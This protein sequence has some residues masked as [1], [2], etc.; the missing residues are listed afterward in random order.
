MVKNP[1]I[2]FKS[3]PSQGS[4]ANYNFTN[5]GGYIFDPGVAFGIFDDASGF[6]T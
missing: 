4:L 2:F 1:F 3:H 6:S 5:D